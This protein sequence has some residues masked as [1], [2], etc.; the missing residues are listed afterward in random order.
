MDT[1]RMVLALALALSPGLLLAGCDSGYA[2]G[3]ITPSPPETEPDPNAG[4]PVIAFVSTR[5]GSPYIY[6]ATADGSGVRRL[7]RGES[8]SWSWDGRR[9]AF[10]RAPGRGPAGIYV[11][12]V[13]GEKMKFL[14]PGA[15]P[16]WSPDGRIAFNTTEWSGPE[17]GIAVMNAD[18]SGARLLVGHS[19]AFESGESEY[20][21]SWG[22]GVGDPSW[23]PDGS[24]ITFLVYPGYYY[25]GAS[26]IYVINADG[27]DPRKLGN[28]STRGPSWSPDGTT[29]A[30]AT[31]TIVLHDVVSGTETF[32]NLDLHGPWVPDA[33]PAWSPDGRQLLF[34]AF[35]Q[36][37][38]WEPTYGLPRRVFAV[39][40]ETGQVRSF[41]PE[42]ANPRRYH[43]YNATWSRGV[44]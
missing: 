44:W 17:G 7:A 31:G 2:L 23:S 41:F 4:P 19:F 43:D 12:G 37:A 33:K 30:S 27:S 11:M 1:R 24:K 5:D 28:W 13:N 14:G 29:L 34:H 39:S 18:G 20:E 38:V 3:P 42:A 40:L 36:G 26:A 6:V 16:V 32:L 22:G 35:D 21:G 8:P 10:T 9:I 25:G 15:D